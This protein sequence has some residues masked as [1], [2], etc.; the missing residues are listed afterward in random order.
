MNLRLLHGDCLEQMVLMVEGSVGAV[1]VD[2]PYGLEFMGKDWDKL[3]P[4]RL[5][6][7]WAGTEKKGLFGDAPEGSK[8][9]Q[10]PSFRPGRNR[11]CRKCNKYAFSGT[12]CQCEDPDFDL[13][14]AEHAAY[15]QQWHAGWLAEALRVLAPGGLIKVFSA[16]RTFHRLAAA[17]D[18]V[19]FGEI[20][21][22]AWTYGSGFP[23]N[24]DIGKALDRTVHRRE[25][26]DKIRAH[27]R[28]WKDE[29]G[30]SNKGINIA[31]GSCPTGSGMAGHWMSRG[32]SQP[33]I[34]TKDQWLKLKDA[35]QWDACELDDLYDAVQ[36]GAERPGTGMTKRVS[37]RPG[38]PHVGES[39]GTMDYEYTNPATPE[40]EI[41]DGW[42]TALKPAW[43]PILIGRK[44][45]RVSAQGGAS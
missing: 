26:F 4:G 17:M 8:F 11:K 5:K 30:F 13:R 43:E 45:G 6:Q 22:E 34:P 36:N 16:S 14:G 15:I 33:E 25:Y 1:L 31:V 9:N 29:R 19:G 41:W 3:E 24:M 23:K 35:L 28:H 38:I 37:K 18:E 12:P 10:L 42:G 44:G 21:L 40:A 32:T 27:L 7:R 2:P 39:Y 20:R